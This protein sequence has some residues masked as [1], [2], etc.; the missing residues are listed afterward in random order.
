MGVALEIRKDR[1]PLPEVAFAKVEID[2]RFT[3]RCMLTN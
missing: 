2:P 1:S 3:L